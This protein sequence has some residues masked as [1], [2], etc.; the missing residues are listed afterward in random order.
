MQ[1]RVLC[2]VTWEQEGPS[3]RCFVR[4]RLMTAHTSL[5]NTHTHIYSTHKFTC[6]YIPDTQ[7][8]HYAHLMHTLVQAH[9]QNVLLHTDWQVSQM[10]LKI[11]KQVRTHICMHRH[12]H[13]HQQMRT[14]KCTKLRAG[15]TTLTVSDVR[16]LLDPVAA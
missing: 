14:P 2:K 6:L 4:K 13:L 1:Q 12:L 16:A 10:P 9:D 7:S 5:S 15:R 11:Y 3:C 8:V